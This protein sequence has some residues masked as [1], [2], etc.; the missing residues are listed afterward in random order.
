VSH[1]SLSDQ[2]KM[3]YYEHVSL[4]NEMQDACNRGTLAYE[5]KGDTCNRGA[6]HIRSPWLKFQ[7]PRSLS[8][9]IAIF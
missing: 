9:H 2:C 6:S 1:V 7:A 3:R 4:F 5:E 8:P